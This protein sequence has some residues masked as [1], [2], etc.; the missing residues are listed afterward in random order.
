MSRPTATPTAQMIIVPIASLHWLPSGQTW[1]E[2]EKA[3]NPTKPKKR[4]FAIPAAPVAMPI[5]LIGRKLA[6]ARG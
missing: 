2:S 5:L 6:A 4:I 1:R 3:T